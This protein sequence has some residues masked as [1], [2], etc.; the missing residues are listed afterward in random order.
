L[1]RYYDENDD[2]EEEDDEYFE[3]GQ[4]R[5]ITNHKDGYI[6]VRWVP[7][8]ASAQ[9]FE[10][11]TLKIYDPAKKRASCYYVYTIK[12]EYAKLPQ[13]TIVETNE[14]TRRQ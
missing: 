8:D 5:T 14:V 13:T 4:H 1:L 10:A 9:D 11:T 12:T 2:A 3:D 6:E 7:I